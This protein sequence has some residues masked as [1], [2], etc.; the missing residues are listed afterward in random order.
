MADRGEGGGRERG[1]GWEEG[2][3]YRK[4]EKKRRKKGM[5]DRVQSMSDKMEGA[6][7]KGTNKEGE[8][9]RDRD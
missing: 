7:K 3:Y 6:L 9:E 1:G 8:R 4:D 5:N 2:I